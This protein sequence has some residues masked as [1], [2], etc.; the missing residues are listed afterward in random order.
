LADYFDANP[1][2]ELT[3][4]DALL[5]FGM[6]YRACV[7][8]VQRMVAHGELETPKIIRRPADKR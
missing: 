7:V 5:K 3:Y 1:G 6:T 4:E 2:E 8:A